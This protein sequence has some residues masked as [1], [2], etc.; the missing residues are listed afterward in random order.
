MNRCVRL[1]V[2]VPGRLLRAELS[3]EKRGTLLEPPT[4]PDL[5]ALVNLQVQT[6]A[7]EQNRKVDDGLNNFLCTPLGSFA[8]FL[9]E[10]CFRRLKW[11]AEVI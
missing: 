10:A 4:E 5:P 6:F 3:L 9:V 1:D 2:E 7:Q 11:I 8:L